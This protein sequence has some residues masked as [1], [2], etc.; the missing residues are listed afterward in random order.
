MDK[1]KHSRASVGN[2]TDEKQIIKAES[3]VLANKQVRVQDEVFSH[4]SKG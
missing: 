1:T 2:A 4:L 3:E